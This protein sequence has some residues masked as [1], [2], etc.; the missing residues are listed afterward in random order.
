MSLSPPG[1][2]GCRR[3]AC[4]QLAFC[5]LASSG[6][7]AAGP[8]TDLEGRPPPPG[9]CAPQVRWRVE[10]RGAQGAP[11]AACGDAVGPGTLGSGLCLGVFAPRAEGRAALGV[12]RD[13]LDRNVRYFGAE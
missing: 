8:A 9:L 10:S 1:V 12:A 2:A 3:A 11:P 5:S 6:A 7:V 13:K 4:P